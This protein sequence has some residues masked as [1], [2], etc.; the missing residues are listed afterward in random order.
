MFNWSCA[1]RWLESTVAEQMHGHSHSWQ[2]ISWSIWMR[3]KES[4]Y[5][6]Y[7]S[8]ET[9]KPATDGTCHPIRPHL[10]ILSKE[11]H[12]LGTEYS[13]LWVCGGH[14]LS[15]HNKEVQ[16]TDIQVLFWAKLCVEFHNNYTNVDHK[17]WIRVF[18][19]LHPYQHLVSIAFLM[20]AILT[21]VKWILKVILI[22]IS[23]VVSI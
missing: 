7:S 10:L 17:H 1:F 20:E 6:W 3:Q 21:G 9:S 5:K 14:S 19:F 23:L 15:N 12:Q 2:L 4:D 16:M 22:L 8:L 18:I 11:F 13:K